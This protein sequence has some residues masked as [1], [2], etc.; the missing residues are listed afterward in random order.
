VSPARRPGA[1][2]GAG[3]TY[4]HEGHLVVTAIQ[5]IPRPRSGHQPPLLERWD[6]AVARLQKLDPGAQVGGPRTEI[7]LDQ[8]EDEIVRLS[9]PRTAPDPAL[10]A[11]LDEII[12]LQRRHHAA[13]AQIKEFQKLLGRHARHWTHE[14]LG[15][16]PADAMRDVGPP[17][18]TTNYR[19]P[20]SR[21]D[22]RAVVAALSPVVLQLEGWR[23]Q[24]Q[25]ALYD[26]PPD[27]QALRLVEA[28]FARVQLLEQQVLQ[29][30]TPKRRSR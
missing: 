5:R 6:A 4:Q 20:T 2:T 21:G 11:V 1:L 3:T 7:G 30:T 15:D 16:I 29:L 12:S 17:P 18:D 13:W 9:K 10:G 26:P 25:A 24:L 14:L 28:L 8:I 27:K 22:A 19:F 23:A